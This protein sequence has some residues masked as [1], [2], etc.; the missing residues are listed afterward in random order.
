[1]TAGGQNRVLPDVFPLGGF[2]IKGDSDLGVLIP[3]IIADAA[4]DPRRTQDCVR[5]TAAPHDIYPKPPHFL[6]QGLAESLI[7]RRVEFPLGNAAIRYRRTAC[8]ILNAL[9]KDLWPCL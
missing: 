1:M 7:D 9:Q 8:A 5:L 2:E 4:L 6:M 3:P